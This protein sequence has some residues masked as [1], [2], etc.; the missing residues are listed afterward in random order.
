MNID[1]FMYFNEEDLLR[2]RLRE[3]DS[4][5]DKFVITELN[6]THS[7]ISKSQSFDIDKYKEFKDKIV[8]KFIDYNLINQHKN[9]VSY[10]KSQNLVSNKSHWE[11]EN[12]QRNYIQIILQSLN[13]QDSDNVLS[14][15]LDEILDEKSFLTC[16]SSIESNKCPIFQIP[17]A[18]VKQRHRYLKINLIAK[19]FGYGPRVMK[20]GLYKKVDPS[21]LREYNVGFVACEGGWHF[22][23]LS[24]DKKNVFTKIKS[25]SHAYQQED[26]VNEDDAFRKVEKLIDHKEDVDQT[27]PKEIIKNK[28]LYLKYI[29]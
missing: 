1:T 18:K 17:V 12:F 28:E 15:D 23:Y 8:Y 22:S 14:S 24:K 20:Y 6:Q 4:F 25:F 3:H 16:A 2:I 19:D 9:I 21:L 11:R 7:G 10:N 26:V 5:I 13:I 29:A 27:Y